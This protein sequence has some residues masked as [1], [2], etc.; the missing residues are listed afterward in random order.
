MISDRLILPANRAASG[1]ILTATPMAYWFSP[2]G[3]NLSQPGIQA[4]STSGL[5]SASQACCCVTANARL[6]CMSMIVRFLGP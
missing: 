1:P 4:L 6:P 5:L 3:S 2:V